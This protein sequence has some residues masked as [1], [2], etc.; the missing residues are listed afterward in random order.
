MIPLQQL[1]ISETEKHVIALH[2]SQMLIYFM[3]AQENNF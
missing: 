2:P 3:F 1:D